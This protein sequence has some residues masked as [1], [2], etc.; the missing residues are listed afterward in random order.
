MSELCSP[1]KQGLLTGKEKRKIFW[2]ARNAHY[3]DLGGDYRTDT[4][5]KKFSNYTLQICAHIYYIL[6]FNF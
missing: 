6:Y 5:C 4:L 1:G 3:L 2:G